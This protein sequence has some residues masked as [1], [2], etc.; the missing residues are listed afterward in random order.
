[1]VIIDWL[2]DLWN[3]WIKPWLPDPP[4]LFRFLTRLSGW[5]DKFRLK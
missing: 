2:K 5:K 4:Q 1:V 3:K